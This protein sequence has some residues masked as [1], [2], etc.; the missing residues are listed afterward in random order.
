MRIRV[1]L[2]YAA[3]LGVHSC[4]MA[5]SND[6]AELQRLCETHGER[7]Q[8]L[9]A[10]LDLERHGLAGVKKAAE[11]KDW[12][13]A[14]AA[15]LGHYRATKTNEWLREPAVQATGGKEP[16]AEEILT[17]RLTFYSMAQKAPRSANGR[18]NWH[19]TK[20]REWNSALH[21]HGQLSTLFGAYCKTGNRD[22]VRYLDGH[23]RDWIESNPYGD[24]RR[25]TMA[26]YGLEPGLRLPHWARVFYGLQ[27]VHEFTPT[28]RILMLSSIPE[29]AHFLRHR[30]KG[31]G[32]N[33]ITMQLHGLA[34]AA[35]CWPE[36]KDA[37]AWYAYAAR[38]MNRA[39][40]DQVHPDGVQTELTSSYHRVALSRFQ[41][42]ADLSARVGKTVPKSY[43]AQLEKMWNYL[44]YSM[45]PD[46][47]G[48]LNNDSDRTHNV[49]HVLGRAVE[50]NRRDWA[51]IATN[52]KDGERPAVGP[53]VVFPW[54]G[55]VIMRS[56]WDRDAHWAFFDVGPYGTG[57]QHTDKLHLSIAA[58][59]RDLLVDAGRFSYTSSWRQ[60][61]RSAA[62]HNIILVDNAGQ[63]ADVS[64]WRK[65]MTENYVI[66]KE[67]DFARGTF[68]RGFRGVK[69]K[70]QHLRSVLYV[71]GTF[72]VVV[73]RIKTDRPRDIQA[74]WHYHPD[75]SV[76]ADGAS[77]TSTDKGKGN[78][79][80]VPVSG[81]K[82]RLKIVKGQ[83]TPSVQG[84]Y[85][86]RY[87]V[88][89]ANA[90][91]VYAGKIEKNATFAWVLVPAQDTPPAAKARLTAETETGVRMRVEL[92]GARPVELTVPIT[93]GQPVV[94]RVEEAEGGAQ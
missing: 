53:S 52:G 65:P 21:R 17:D 79:R 72:W 20:Y 73:D 29:H 46:G 42:F 81:P 6:A 14:C 50:F 80:I 33:W 45:R 59:G 68:D 40:K 7:V 28:T 16:R 3:V 34:T 61:F 12:P 39:T 44:A 24:K 37:S 10:S 15:L 91:A 13:G 56:G 90:T 66:S 18:L 71:K 25:R 62:G 11:A 92:P 2:F 36:F 84:W 55:Q 89:Q 43:K 5:A 76:V 32:G 86:V 74:L 30:H 77:V 69:G 93:R 78:L 60:Y 58:F 19:P 23:V 87:N 1:L 31:T 67:F 70:V 54:A 83:K 35:I 63:N 4:A 82:W 26:W 27:A 8:K 57:H 38:M 41:A 51:Y 75:C 64:K 85:S 48:V 49:P 94:T 9:F 47:A 22:Y 88:K